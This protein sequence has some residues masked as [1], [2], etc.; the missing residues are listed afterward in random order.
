VTPDRYALLEADNFGG[1]AEPTIIDAE[2]L[3]TDLAG[4][5]RPMGTANRDL[6]LVNHSANRHAQSLVELFQRLVPSDQRIAAPLRELGRLVRVGWMAEWRA[7]HWA[8]EAQRLRA[9][10]DDITAERDR[11]AR[12]NEALRAEAAGS[13]ER[14]VEV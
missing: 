4:Y 11:L 2:R 14:V 10:L 6:A 5:S 8:G 7:V 12:E 13:V 1:Q 9:E 3:R